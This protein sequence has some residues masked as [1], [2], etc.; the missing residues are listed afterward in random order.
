M[1][2]FFALF[3]VFLAASSTPA[4]SQSVQRIV[5]VV[6][7][8]VISVRDL[9]Q[10]IRL[11]LFSSGIEDTT[12][13][14]QRVAN[15]VLRT[16]IDERLQL[17]EGGK[18]NVKVS[19]DDIERNISDIERLNGMEPNSLPSV[20]RRNRVSYDSLRAQVRARIA[21]S[22]L[23]R[24]R[25]APRIDIGAEEVAEILARLKASEGE[26]TYRLGEIFLSVNRPDE[27]A[28][29]RETAGRLVEQIRGGARFSALARQFS[30]TATAAVGGDLGW[31]PR[32]ELEPAVAAAVDLL[33]PGEVLDPIRSISGFRIVTLIDRRK[34]AAKDPNETELK[35]KQIFVP[36]PDGNDAASTEA[37]IEFVG[38]EA[39][40]IDGCDG[41]SALAER[42]GVEAP[43]DLGTVKRAELSAEVRRNVASVAVG[44]AT[45]P[46][47]VPGGVVL[48]AVC[49][50]TLPKSD[51]PSPETVTERLRRQRLDLSAQ[52]YLRDLRSAAIIDLR[53]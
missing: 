21:W 20:F 31:T 46:M 14:R 42:L 28:A 39:N 18:R 50:R 7:D 10:R 52:R 5:A 48:M 38:T 27:E 26:D 53:I 11:V 29:I 17:Q 1:R 2:P 9:R 30:Q 49:A 37:R 24:R 13:S 6:N 45:R 4:L 41:L 36:V 23:V 44:K 51:L 15:Q 32:S 43:Q 35:L 3:L 40:A 12:E 33:S 47:R 16:L 8:E 25:L 19:D 22:T 34:I